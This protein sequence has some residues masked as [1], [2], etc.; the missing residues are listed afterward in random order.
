MTTPGGERGSGLLGLHHVQLSCPRGGE[1]ASRRF[2]VDAVGLTEMA[3]PASLLPP[4]GC[5][6]VAPGTTMAVH[7]GVEQSFQPAARAHPA[8][9][10]ADVDRL[11]ALAVRLRAAGYDVRDDELL[12]GYRRFY[13][14]DAHGNRVE[15]L[16]R[17]PRTPDP[18]F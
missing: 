11:Q 6:F 14:D 2:W 15:F 12:P 9:L 3:K 18:G 1:D 13:T 7:V 4:G 17:N 5:W 10:L 16:A 8:L